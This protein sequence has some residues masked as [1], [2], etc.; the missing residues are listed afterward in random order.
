MEERTRQDVWKDF[1]DESLHTAEYVESLIDALE[2][3]EGT[4]IFSH[5]KNLLDK[6]AAFNGFM[7]IMEMNEHSGKINNPDNWRTAE[8]MA[9]S[10]TIMLMDLDDSIKEDSRQKK[11]LNKIGQQV[12]KFAQQLQQLRDNDFPLTDTSSINTFP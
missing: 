3:K 2:A 10:A 4:P 7:A 5:M 12:E 8:D 11:I 1:G 9:V 6:F